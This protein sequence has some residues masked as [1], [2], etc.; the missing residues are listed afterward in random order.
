MDNT[1][2]SLIEKYGS[3]KNIS[4]YS[5][6]YNYV[7][8]TNGK[9]KINSFLEIGVGTL[10][11]HI[12]SSFIGNLN[13]FPEYKPGNSLRAYREFFPNAQIY[14]VDV[15]EDCRMEEDRLKTFI[16]DSTDLQLCNKNLGSNSFDIIIDDGLHTAHG[17]L[18][19]LKNL[20]NR[21][22]YDGFYVIE[23]LGGGGD[24][25]NMFV[26]LREEAEK[27]IGEHEYYFRYN[28][29]IIKKSFSNKRE[30][31]DPSEFFIQAAKTDLT[32]VTGL[33][34]IGRPGRSFDHYMAS[35]E[36]LLKVKQNLV[37]PDYQINHLHIEFAKY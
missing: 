23:D 6:L 9:E 31:R 14:G 8:E 28:V 7:F 37:Y 16:F 26:E 13:Y 5:E 2:S 36:Q 15:A 20:F 30:L 24:S 35:F 27:I 12:P 3:D 11:P 34:D 25:M 22:R 33:W 17:Q 29:L 21:V 10:E 32:I 19:T 4:A 18:Q 1:L